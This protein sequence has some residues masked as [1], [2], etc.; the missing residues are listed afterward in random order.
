[1]HVAV[2]DLLD[3]CLAPPA[4]WEPYPAGVTRLSPA[5]FAQ[6]QRFGIKRGMPDIM[7]FYGAAYGI[8]LKR[9]GGQLTKTKIVHTRRGT[10]RELLGQEEM[11]QRLLKSG[12][13]ASIQVARNI[14]DVCML[15][16]MWKIPRLGGHG[17]QRML[18][19]GQR[20]VT[21]AEPAPD[22]GDISA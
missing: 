9:R 11:H 19:S 20:V 22:V 1:M 4:V 5:Q 18:R 14:D 2:R 16:D 6:Y 3:L 12:A 10:P 15:L 13:F 8:E 7:V 21:Y 17:W